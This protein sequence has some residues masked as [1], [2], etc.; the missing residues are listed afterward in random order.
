M[1]ARVGW[2]AL[3]G[4]LMVSVTTACGAP[5]APQGGIATPGGGTPAPVE[6]AGQIPN[7]LEPAQAGL[8]RQLGAPLEQIV[9]TSYEA[10]QWPDACLGAPG[11]D[12][13][14]AQV[15][16]PGY[17]GLFK[18][19]AGVVEVHTDETGQDFRFSG[20]PQGGGPIP[21]ALRWER[22]G[23]IA[24]ICQV[25]ELTEKGA[26]TLQDCATGLTT[27]KGRLAGEQLTHLQDLISR[28][29]P[30]EWKVIPPQGSADLFADRLVFPGKGGQTASEQEQR[31]IADFIAALATEL[32][33]QP[34]L[35]PGFTGLKIQ[36]WLTQTCPGPQ[37]VDTPCPDRPYQATLEILTADGRQVQTMQT[38]AQG[39][40]QIPL[41]PGNYIIR[42]SGAEVFPRAAE[43]TVTVS[44]GQAT[45]VTL[46]FDSGIR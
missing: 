29:A 23:G 20:L 43:Q 39:R 33:Q 3:L 9:F 13:L 18:T 21:G 17:R 41:E 34:E 15:I 32:G 31:E 42:Q 40:V 26:Y 4:L 10:I 22:S 27:A 28:Y 8:A 7:V 12:E 2:I 19:P 5:T 30:F 35:S 36:A 14:C 38:D 45:V 16:T 44:A 24:G 11:P 25:L 37:R 1:S 46:Y 6:A